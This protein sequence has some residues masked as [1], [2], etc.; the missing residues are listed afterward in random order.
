MRCRAQT[1][2]QRGFEIISIIPIRQPAP[3]NFR[4]A[5]ENTFV[6]KLPWSYS[7]P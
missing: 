2:I 5:K 7:R 1:E 6:R 4:H 3:L